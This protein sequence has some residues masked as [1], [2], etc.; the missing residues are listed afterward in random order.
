MSNLC[1]SFCSKRGNYMYSRRDIGIR[2]KIIRQKNCLSQ[3]EV[4]K[5]LGVTQPVY[6]DYE[7]G[8]TE[9]PVSRLARLADFY[10]VS[11]DCL[12]GRMVF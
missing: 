9:I 8:M 3:R 10:K 6:S 5:A 1:V 11:L 7:R 2:L 12:V 4:S